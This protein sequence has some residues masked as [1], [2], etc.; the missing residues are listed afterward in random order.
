[1]CFLLLLQELTLTA[2][3]IDIAATRLDKDEGIF[4]YDLYMKMLLKDCK[5]SGQTNHS[6]L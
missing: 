2:S 4:M 6:F 1:M 5:K 3:K